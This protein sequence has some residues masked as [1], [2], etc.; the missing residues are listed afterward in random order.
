MP[1][2]SIKAKG[3]QVITNT[4]S[5]LQERANIAMNNLL[6]NSI[7]IGEN[8]VFEILD[9]IENCETE[10]VYGY[11]QQKGI[12]QKP[13]PIY[14]GEEL[15]TYSLN[16]K[17][18]FDY[19]NPDDIIKRLK[20][21]AEQQEV[22]SYFQDEKYIGE[23]VITKIGENVLSKYQ[24]VILYAEIV[25]DLLEVPQ[26]QEE[27][28]EQQTKTE[29]EPPADAQTVTQSKFQNAVT[30]AKNTAGSVFERLTDKVIDEALRNAESYVNSSIGG[31]IG[32]IL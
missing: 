18:H 17:L 12:G 22:F 29:V 8:D 1:D 4:K 6:G 27:S 5:D 2:F 9:K 31:T 7:R 20:E 14:T 23:Y 21:K 19:C 16:I 11:S 26:E 3:S 30:V 13:V 28:Y 15:H 10:T 32:G 25:V 24:G